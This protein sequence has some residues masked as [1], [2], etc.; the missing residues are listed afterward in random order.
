MYFN[1]FKVKKHRLGG[2]YLTYTDARE[3]NEHFFQVFEKLLLVA[4]TGQI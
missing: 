3:S 1:N 4:H 2:F